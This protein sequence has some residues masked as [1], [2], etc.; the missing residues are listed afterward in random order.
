MFDGKE[1]KL[2]DVAHLGGGYAFKST[3]YT[4]AGR[5]ILRTV[6]IRK[7]TSITK[8]GAKFISEERSRSVRTFLP[9]G[10]R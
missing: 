10:A 1:V 7:D 5:F 4:E 8:G 3:Q 9:Q 6:N 2:S